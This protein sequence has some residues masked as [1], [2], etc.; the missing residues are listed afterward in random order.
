MN[1]NEKEIKV[2]EIIDKDF[3]NSL[4]IYVYDSYCSFSIEDMGLMT[5][6]FM[7]LPKESIKKLVKILQEIIENMEEK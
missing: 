3:C 4:K 5:R 6:S 1:N 2:I 7:D